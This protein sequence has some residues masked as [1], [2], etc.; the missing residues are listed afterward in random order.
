MSITLTADVSAAI[1]AITTVRGALKILR[2]PF[3]EIGENFITTTY[4][5]FNKEIDP[6][7]VRW[8]PNADSTLLRYMQ[9][10]AGGKALSKKLTATGGRTVTSKGMRAL[11]IKKILRDSGTLQDLMGYQASDNVLAFGPSIATKDYAATMQYGNPSKRIPA[12]PYL[13]ITP[14]DVT[15]IQD[16]FSKYFIDTWIANANV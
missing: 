1:K 8:T 10:K 2:L 9:K 16:T 6:Q 14:N 7:G 12:R 5:R 15:F 3:G 4:E 11:A 13:G